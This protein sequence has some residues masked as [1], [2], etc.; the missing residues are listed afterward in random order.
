[1]ASSRRANTSSTWVGLAGRARDAHVVAR[2]DH[3]LDALRVAHDRGAELAQPRVVARGVLELRVDEPHQHG[4]EARLALDRG[5]ERV[6]GPALDRLAEASAARAFGRRP[7][8]VELGEQLA[9]LRA[10][11]LGERDARLLVELG[12]R[13]GVGGFLVL[14]PQ[15]QRLERVGERLR[16]GHGGL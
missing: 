13:V 11:F 2:V 10:G 12:E 8:L 3:G 7:E 15:A 9:D 5:R 4:V 6:P 14:E 1:M 16:V